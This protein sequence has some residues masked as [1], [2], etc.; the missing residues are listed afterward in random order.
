MSSNCIRS[1]DRRNFWEHDTKDQRILKANWLPYIF[2][3]IEILVRINLKRSIRTWIK[4]IKYKWKFRR[5]T[6]RNTWIR[7]S[8]ILRYCLEKL[9]SID[10]FDPGDLEIKLSSGIIW[11]SCRRYKN[12]WYI[13]N[14]FEEGNIKIKIY[15][16]FDWI[17]KK[18]TS[19]CLRLILRETIK[20]ISGYRWDWWKGG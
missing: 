4:F 3:K 20:W 2:R 19:R 15:F 16:E 10:V 18:L 17:A 5:V 11:V 1:R 7:E 13:L 6:K 14:V 12:I 8:G 9:R